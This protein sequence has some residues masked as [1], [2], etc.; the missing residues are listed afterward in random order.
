MEI[1]VILGF[2]LFIIDVWVVLRIA[3]SESTEISKAMWIA[4][5]LV[6]PIFAHIA[7]YLT[8]PGRPE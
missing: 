5:I 8:G 4:T 1:A 6:L 3:R 2:L 7:W